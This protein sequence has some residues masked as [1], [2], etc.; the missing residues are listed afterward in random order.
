[1]TKR[2]LAICCAI[3]E[4]RGLRYRLQ[5]GS[6]DGQA[7]VALWFSTP[8][9]IPVE[10]HAGSMWGFWTFLTLGQGRAVG[11]R[12]QHQFDL[13]EKERTQRQDEEELEQALWDESHG[14]GPE[15]SNEGIELRVPRRRTDEPLSDTSHAGPCQGLGCVH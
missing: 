14:A 9:G 1:M 6:R 13:M 7:S 15:D 10:V 2:E 11:A 8:G 12:Q 3:L 4:W 5:P